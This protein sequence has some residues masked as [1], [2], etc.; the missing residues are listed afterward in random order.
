MN[1][2]DFMRAFFRINDVAMIFKI[3]IGVDSFLDDVI[4]RNLTNHFFLKI[5]IA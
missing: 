5:G 3:S 2:L 1:L 4:S